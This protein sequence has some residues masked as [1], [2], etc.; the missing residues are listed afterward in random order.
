MLGEAVEDRI[1]RQ[2]HRERGKRAVRAVLR[3]PAGEVVAG[4]GRVADARF[5]D[6]RASL[7]LDRIAVLSAVDVE[8][9]HIAVDHDGTVEVLVFGGE[10]RVGEGRAVCVLPAGEH[11][12]LIHRDG[13]RLERFTVLTDLGAERRRALAQEETDR[14]RFGRPLGG[15]R[16]VRCRILIDGIG[17]GILQP[18]AEGVARAGGILRNVGHSRIE[19][20]AEHHHLLLV[21]EFTAVRVERDAGGVS[22]IPQIQDQRIRGLASDN[23][24]KVRVLAGKAGI[25]FGGRRDFGADSSLQHL[26]FIV[27]HEAACCRVLL[28]MT[29]VVSG[30]LADPLRIQRD[31]ILH[32]DRERGSVHI[33]RIVR[34]VGQRPAQ[35]IVVAA[36]RGRKLRR[37]ALLG[38]FNGVER[39]AAVGDKVD[40]AGLHRG[41]GKA[42]VGIDDAVDRLIP[43]LGVAVRSVCLQTRGD[44][45]AGLLGRSDEFGR[46]EKLC[47]FRGAVRK[48]RAGKHK[49]LE[50]RDV[51]LAVG[52]HA[53]TVRDVGS[54]IVNEFVVAVFILER[55]VVHSPVCGEILAGRRDTGLDT[56]GRRAAGPDVAALVVEQREVRSARRRG[57]GAGAGDR[58]RH[59]N[60]VL[61]GRQVA[62]VVID[63]K[64]VVR[65]VTVRLDGNRRGDDVALRNRVGRVGTQTECRGV[66]LLDVCGDERDVLCGNGRQLIRLAVEHP[67]AEHIVGLGRNRRRRD[68]GAAVDVLVRGRIEAGRHNA[69]AGIEG[70]GEL[71]RGIDGEQR[72]IVAADGDRERSGAAGASGI[73]V[74]ALEGK[75]FLLRVRGSFDTRTD[76]DRQEDGIFAVLRIEEHVA[77]VLA[78]IVPAVE[79]DACLRRRRRLGNRRTE[80]IRDGVGIRVAGELAAVGIEG[81]GERVCRPLGIHDAQAAE[82]EA[83]PVDGRLQR[84]I[85][86]PAEE[87]AA[88]LGRR[89]GRAGIGIAV[90]ADGHRHLAAAHRIEFKRLAGDLPARV[91]GVRHAGVVDLGVQIG[92]EVRARGIEV[93]RPA[94]GFRRL[95]VEIPAG[96]SIVLSRGIGRRSRDLGREGRREVCGYA[97]HAVRVCIELDAHQLGRLILRSLDQ[98]ID[99]VHEV[100]A[101]LIDGALIARVERRLFDRLVVIEI[102]LD[103]DVVDRINERRGKRILIILAVCFIGVLHEEV[104]IVER[105]RDRGIDALD[106]GII[107]VRVHHA[108]DPRAAAVVVRSRLRQSRNSVVD[109]VLRDVLFAVDE[110]R[111]LQRLEILIPRS[112]SRAGAGIRV[113][114]LRRLVV[115]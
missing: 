8:R 83:A 80:Q 19:Q 23:A 79:S 36:G 84:F 71:Q 5:G 59:R 37:T 64:T 90:V 66:G 68:R 108:G 86:V 49:E 98:R 72:H 78:V 46:H 45:A 113:A 100:D 60:A 88:G 101:H 2:R 44:L 27:I 95:G 103:L 42:E 81:H 24:G 96:E 92:L 32:R 77:H 29:D 99:R 22:Q 51:H 110:P 70:D 63:H 67:C 30:L 112:E 76:V 48:R 13:R 18:A 28:V 87:P 1:L 26:L 58:G 6:L 56:S 33:V 7:Y 20:A 9:Q 17:R 91:Q 65:H 102:V 47:V 3:T 11:V 25:H 93:K 35:E 85:G 62:L 15:Q 21:L 104:G 53:R 57:T 55:A 14:D 73:A 106:A 107:R 61:C 40:A 16:D 12:A 74:P 52:T 10:R 31:G 115:V 39:I 109:V 41:N 54:V 75:A 82:R 89:L 34:V 43:I 50:G 97:R 69:L 4:V 105:L 111:V 114:E 38:V 94:H